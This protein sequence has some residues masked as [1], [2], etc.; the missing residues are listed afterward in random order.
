[1]TNSIEDAL[2]RLGYTLPQP[3]APQGSY[4][5]VVQT[6]SLLFVSGQLP[7][8]PNGLECVGRCGETVSVADAQAAAR[9]CALHILAHVKNALGGDLSRLVRIVKVNGFVNSTPDFG[10]HPAVINGASNL[11]AEVMGDSGRH[12]RAAVGVANLPFGAAVEVEG[13]VEIAL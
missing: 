8:G 7:M 5:P 9:L 2:T 6:G 1:M 11:F 4:V 3:T 10:D 12:A 13:V